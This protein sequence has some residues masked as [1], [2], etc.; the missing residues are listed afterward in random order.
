MDDKNRIIC[1]VKELE[2]VLYY[3]SNDGS[4]AVTNGVSKTGRSL[5]TIVRKQDIIDHSS[6]WSEL[7][8]NKSSCGVYLAKIWHLRLGNSMPVKFIRLKIASGIL[9]YPK[10][11]QTECIV[12]TRVKIRGI[13]GGILTIESRLGRLHYYTKCQV[14]VTSRDG[15]LYF[16]T[17][18]DEYSRFTHVEPL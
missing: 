11:F 16:Q 8:A 6:V 7:A 4:S 5:I 2:D 9:P 17:I 10:C 1:I 13:F 3:I 12:F 18:V 15:H 14:S